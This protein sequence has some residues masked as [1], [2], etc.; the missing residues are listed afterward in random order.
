M[1]SRYVE[2]SLTILLN[3]PERGWA[4]RTVLS[5]SWWVRR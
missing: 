4:L 3:S 5:I 2:R 1:P